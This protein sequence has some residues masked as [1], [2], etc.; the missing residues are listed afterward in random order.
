MAAHV[1]RHAATLFDP[2]HLAVPERR[3]Q[4]RA[5]QLDGELRDAVR[6]AE[7]ARLEGLVHLVVALPPGGL[8]P[9]LSRPRAGPHVARDVEG[10]TLAVAEAVNYGAAAAALLTDGLPEGLRLA[11]VPAQVAALGHHQGLLA[12]GQDLWL[13]L[14]QQPLVPLRGRVP[15]G[16]VRRWDGPL[17]SGL[18]GLDGEEEHPSQDGCDCD[19]PQHPANRGEKTLDINAPKIRL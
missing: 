19:S 15:L 1:H 8:A 3:L 16:L 11:P 7:G 2:L 9:T 6:P 12:G 17:G 18:L 14:V 10:V 13:L 4:V 5:V